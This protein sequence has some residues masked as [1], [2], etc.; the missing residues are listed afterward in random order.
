MCYQ[1]WKNKGKNNKKIFV[2]LQGNYHGDTFGAMSVRKSYNFYKP[3]EDLLFDTKYLPYSETWI[4]DKD[5]IK[6][7]NIAIEYTKEFLEKNS[8]KVVCFLLESIVQGA[9]GMRMVRPEFVKKL[10][11]IFRE[12][13]IP[14]IFD[15]VM[16]GFCRTGTIFLY[17][18]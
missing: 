12:H 2:T 9:S 5:I 7:E 16:T 11:N 10:C 13:N 3:F 8:E 1:F 15:E 17:E 18:K 6:K 4:N 14:V